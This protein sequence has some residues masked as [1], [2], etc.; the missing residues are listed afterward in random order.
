MLYHVLKHFS[1]VSA[2]A[3]FRRHGKVVNMRR[4]FKI[5]YGHKSFYGAAFVIGKYIDFIGGVRKQ[6][7]VLLIGSVL[8][9]RKAFFNNLKHS[10]K[11][12]GNEISDHICNLRK[13]I[14]TYVRRGS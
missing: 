6:L 1:A 3:E 7:F 13:I 8:I 11:I 10:V 2:V 9:P 5:P 12:F 4:L 14:I